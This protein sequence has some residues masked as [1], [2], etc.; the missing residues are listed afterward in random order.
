MLGN[1]I[2]REKIKNHIFHSIHFRISC[3]SEIRQ[4]CPRKKACLL[5]NGNKLS[6]KQ[7][8]KQSKIRKQ[9]KYSVLHL[10]QSYH[11]LT[12]IVSKDY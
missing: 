10:L 4:R 3:K 5:P 6:S 8:D 9:S 11:H 7:S 1:K 12:K 2:K